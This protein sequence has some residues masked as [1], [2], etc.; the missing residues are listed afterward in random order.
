MP[1]PPP[2]MS[3]DSKPALRRAAVLG[4]VPLEP[5]WLIWTLMFPDGGAP[6]E[7]MNLR[8]E[9]DTPRPVWDV[10]TNG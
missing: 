10:W 5:E 9:D 1:L 4:L 8:R 3:R 6:F 2:G 7:S